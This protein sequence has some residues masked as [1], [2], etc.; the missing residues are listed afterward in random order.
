MR[1]DKGEDGSSLNKIWD[2]SFRQDESE[3]QDNIR[4]ASGIGKVKGKVSFLISGFGPQ[5]NIS[6]MSSA[7]V[8][9]VAPLYRTKSS[10]LLEKET[11]LILMEIS[12]KQSE[13]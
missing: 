12:K 9:D 3:F 11:T 6:V 1:E 2:V 4:E 10:L 7:A 5:F 13:S 8:A